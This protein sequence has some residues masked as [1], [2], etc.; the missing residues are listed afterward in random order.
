MHMQ[1]KSLTNLKKLKSTKS[2][3]K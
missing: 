2:L 1:G 3:D